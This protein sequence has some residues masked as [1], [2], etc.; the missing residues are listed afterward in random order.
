MDQAGDNP[1]DLRCLLNAL[2]AASPERHGPCPLG[3]AETWPVMIGQAVYAPKEV[4]AG[5]YLVSTSVAHCEFMQFDH[6]GTPLSDVYNIYIIYMCASKSCS[7]VKQPRR[8]KLMKKQRQRVELKRQKKIFLP[9]PPPPNDDSQTIT[10]DNDRQQLQS[11]ITVN[12]QQLQSTIQSTST[13]NNYS[14]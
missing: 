7:A 10:V 14:Q 3:H 5:D 12:S 4:Q 13:V 11:T 9:P 2:A 8:A 6:T 1:T